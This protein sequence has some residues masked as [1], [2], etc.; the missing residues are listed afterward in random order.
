MREQ[1][2]GVHRVLRPC[3][4][5]LFCMTLSWVG[6]PRD[7]LE[8]CMTLSWVGSP[9]LAPSTLP[10]AVPGKPQLGYSPKEII[11]PAPALTSKMQMP[12]MTWLHH[13]FMRNCLRL[14]SPFL[15]CS[16][17]KP[18]SHMNFPH[19]FLTYHLSITCMDLTHLAISLSYTLCHISCLSLLLFHVCVL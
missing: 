13:R 7:F 16:I 18:K 10:L 2:Q 3:S 8:S 14:R 17:L 15:S 4:S 5:G 9:M 6:W 12:D 11:T 19:C 1:V